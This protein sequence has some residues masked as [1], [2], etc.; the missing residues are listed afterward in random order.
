[1]QNGV[2][3]TIHHFTEVEEHATLTITASNEAEAIFH[4]GYNTL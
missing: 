2:S 3:F 4:G 1:M